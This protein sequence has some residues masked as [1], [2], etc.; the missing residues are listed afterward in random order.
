MR[1]FFGACDAQIFSRRSACRSIKPGA[2]FCQSANVWRGFFGHRSGFGTHFCGL[3][4]AQKLD[5]PN[6]TDMRNPVRDSPRADTIAAC[7][8]LDRGRRWRADRHQQRAGAAIVARS[9]TVLTMPIDALDERQSRARKSK[10]K[11]RREKFFV[12]NQCIAITRVCL[13]AT[14]PAKDQG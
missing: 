11:T 14:S 6:A 13:S 3:F 2:D 4:F 5:R 12:M 1:I 9:G 7:S 8:W 10:L